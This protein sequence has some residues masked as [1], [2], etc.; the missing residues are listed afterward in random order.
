MDS[1]LEGLE[2]VL[3]L[4]ISVK[5]LAA[6]ATLATPARLIRA[7]VNFILMVLGES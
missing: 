4:G 3:P 6:L 1:E 2:N 5:D 7:A